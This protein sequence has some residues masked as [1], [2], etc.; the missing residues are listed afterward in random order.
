MYFFFLWE[1]CKCPFF[2]SEDIVLL[3]MILNSLS[4][5]LIL[6]E[7]KD[8]IKEKLYIISDGWFYVSTLLGYGTQLFGQTSI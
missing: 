4:Y 8:T 7:I 2:Y 1:V 5:V 3:R 6:F